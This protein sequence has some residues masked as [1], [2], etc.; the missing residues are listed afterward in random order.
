MQDG[1]GRRGSSE[2]RGPAA[3]LIK[4]HPCC[5][6]WDASNS[7]HDICSEVPSCGQ[8]LGLGAGGQGVLWLSLG[9]AKAA[10]GRP[11]ACWSLST[12]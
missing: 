7:S 11:R 8:A 3:S 9:E 1:G 6:Q 5:V 10:L 12:F 4:G 2:C